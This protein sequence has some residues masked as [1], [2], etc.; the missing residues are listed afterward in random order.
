MFH[1][2]MRD[3]VLALSFSEM[4]DHWSFSDAVATC[5]TNHFHSRVQ[6]FCLSSCLV[7]GSRWLCHLSSACMY[8]QYSWFVRFDD[9]A[10]LKAV[11]LS[12]RGIFDLGY[13]FQIEKDHRA[14]YPYANSQSTDRLQYCAAWFLP[15]LRRALTSK[16]IVHFTIRC[17][18]WKF[19]I[20]QQD[21]RACLFSLV[22]KCDV[23]IQLW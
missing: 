22:S 9:G 5:V 15:R 20:Y 1:P 11:P 8:C 4:L 12:S 14:G 17:T 10:P 2:D 18:Y 6:V 7:F 23:C 16:A 13:I 3:I 21:P 19:A